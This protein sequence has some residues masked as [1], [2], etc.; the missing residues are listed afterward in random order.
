MAGVAGRLDDGLDAAQQSSETIRTR[1]GH[2][3]TFAHHHPDGPMTVT[4]DQLAAWVGD[5]TR[6]PRTAYSIRA[7]MRSF[8]KFLAADGHRADDPAAT[9]PPIRLPR[10]RPRPAPD[11]AVRH[12]YATVTDARVQLAIRILV[13]TGLRRAEVTRLTVSDV[14]GGRATGRCTLSAR[15]ATSGPSPSA[16]TWPR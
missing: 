9:L 14:E 11:D 8:F 15:G 4:H 1:V 3:V 16:T 12:A 10:S 13:E 7:S 6:K 5:R 2:L